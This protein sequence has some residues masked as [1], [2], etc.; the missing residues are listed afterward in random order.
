MVP[1]L[2]HRTFRFKRHIT[3]FFVLAYCV[4]CLPAGQAGIA[5]LIHAQPPDCVRV[6]IIQ[7]V[8]S[9]R[10]K[11]KGPYEA[12]DPISSITLNK[13]RNL[14]TTITAY[15][16]GILLGNM[17]TQSDKLFI[18]PGGPDPVII[19][20]RRFRGN[21]QLIRNDKFRLSA[22]NYIELEDYVKGILYHEVSHY[23]PMEALKIQAIVSRTFAV[24]Q[25]QENKLKDFDVTSDVYSQVYGGRASERYRTNKAVEETK[26]KIIFYNGKVL[27]AFFHSV[28]GGHTQDASLLWNIDIIA[29]KGVVCG[30]CKESPRF[31]WHCVLPLSEIKEK[32]TASGHSLKE[33][34]DIVTLGKDPSGRNTALKIVTAD[35][36]TEIS[37]KDF[38]NIIGPNVIRS[39]NFTV[40][41]EAGDAVFEGF[42]WGH[43][44]G[45]C[46]WGAY[47]MAK[48]GR[49]AEEILRYYYPDSQISSVNY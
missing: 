38:R 23:W 26:G 30:F 11:L 47:F 12:I 4:L 25:M 49:S 28:C 35:K 39:A 1:S 16:G 18:R 22:I 15:K 48:E 31:S 34:T 44:V 9:L 40:R 33:I 36:E 5:S 7:D 41:T 29:L 45:L 17:K 37:A 20:G 27:P 32:L 42:G 24:Y 14:N 21:I 43:G 10:L 8:S 19:N 13:G 2:K 3:Q 6:I 46:Q